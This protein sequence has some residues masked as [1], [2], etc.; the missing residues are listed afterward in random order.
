MKVA[1]EKDRKEEENPSRMNLSGQGCAT[2]VQLSSQ[3]CSRSGP[4][5]SNIG[6]N[7]QLVRIG[8]IPN[9]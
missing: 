7:C 5:S 1:N 6:I 3:W 4:W 2:E 9:Y 8:P